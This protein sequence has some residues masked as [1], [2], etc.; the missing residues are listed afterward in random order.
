MKTITFKEP[1]IDIKKE[2]H[3]I[4]IEI[5]TL[6]ATR[7]DHKLMQAAG[8]TRAQIKQEIEDLI[9]ERNQLLSQ[10]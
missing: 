7:N 5:Q 4:N 10:I 6:E 8:Y 9:K 3:D 1:K 2:I